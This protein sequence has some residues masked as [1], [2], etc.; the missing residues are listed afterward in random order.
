MLAEL[1]FHLD[2]PAALI[3]AVLFLVATI[4]V[5][6]WRKPALPLLSHMLLLI[7]LVLLALAAGG[8][9]WLKPRAQGVLV[10]VDLSPSTRTAGYR[11]VSDLNQRLGQLLGKTPYRIVYFGAENRDGVSTERWASTPTLQDLPCE[12]TIFQPAPANAIVLFSD[13]QFELPASAPPTYVVLDALL[14]G[15]PDAS[16]RRLEIHDGAIA[17]SVANRTG[18][19]R[20]L[21][22]GGG[23]AATTRPIENGSYVVTQAMAP[24]AVGVSASL[25]G[26]DPWPENDQL[27][28]LAPPPAAAER[29]WVSSRSA[30]RLA[31]GDLSTASAG[32]RGVSGA[33]DHRPG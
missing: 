24:N 23:S 33:V 15:P 18:A 11:N 22:I 27:S 32:G 13:A 10:M 21:L 16:V 9:S 31:S 17:V 4:A 5:A 12:R 3:V 30:G 1:P 7:G 28:I 8:P 19:V 29:W 26:N 20:S 14:E 25:A 2:W 6:V